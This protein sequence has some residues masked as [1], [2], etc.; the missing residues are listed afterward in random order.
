MTS[1]GQYWG[2][3]SKCSLGQVQAEK[4]NEGDEFSVLCK[5][6]LGEMGRGDVEDD[7]AY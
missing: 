6:E 3:S 2:Y 5:K 1:H 4:K 7:G